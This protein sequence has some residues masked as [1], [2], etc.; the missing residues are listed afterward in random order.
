MPKLQK[1]FKAYKNTSKRFGKFEKF[2]KL[3]ENVWNFLIVPEASLKS[4]KV[5]LGV[6]QTRRS[7]NGW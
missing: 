2:L 7:A 4:R 5:N 3:S 1:T 6:F